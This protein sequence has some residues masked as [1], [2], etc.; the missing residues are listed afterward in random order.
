M[1]F[2]NC[3]GQTV[4]D[5]SEGVFKKICNTQWYAAPLNIQKCIMMIMRRSM[6]T[7]TLIYC[8]GLFLS[9]LEG[10]ATVNEQLV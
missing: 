7:S 1:F 8:L 2:C 4:I 3:I 5:H 10:F 9:S 6:K